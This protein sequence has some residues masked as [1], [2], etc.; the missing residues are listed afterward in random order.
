MMNEFESE[1]KAT[2]KANSGRKNEY[3]EEK[4]KMKS[5]LSQ[6]DQ[7]Y[8]TKEKARRDEE[9][10]VLRVHQTAQAEKLAKQIH[11]EEEA[12]QKSFQD[13]LESLTGDLAAALEKSRLAQKQDLLK[14]MEEFYDEKLSL[15]TSFNQEHIEKRKIE[16]T[17]EEAFVT[18]FQAAYLETLKVQHEQQHTFL[19]NLFQTEKEERD[20]K[21]LSGDFTINPGTEREKLNHEQHVEQLLYQ[22]EFAEQMKLLTSNHEAWSV[23]V[24]KTAEKDK[25]ELTAR[26]SETLNLLNN[27]LTTFKA[28]LQYCAQAE[29]S[30]LSK[31][32][33]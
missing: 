25:K 18:E 21:R 11:E 13:G 22:R 15:V 3:K 1:W 2:I 31:Q 16:F 17:N 4:G 7:D 26:K 8:Q 9:D 28:T 33:N 14:L 23:R 32:S 6:A 19:E 20:R 29:P 5:K 30:E 12:L 10:S 27:E 24:E